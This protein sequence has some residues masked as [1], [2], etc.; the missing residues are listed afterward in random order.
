MSDVDSD[1]DKLLLENGENK[2]KENYSESHT[3]KGVEGK[4]NVFL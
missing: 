4:L 2:D 1:I 3:E